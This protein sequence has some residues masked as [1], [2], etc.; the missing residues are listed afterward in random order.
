[1][2]KTQKRIVLIGS[3]GVGKTTLLNKIKN[4]LDL[5]IIE[6]QARIIC[7]EQ[8]FK[9]IYEIK[10]SNLFRQAVLKKQITLEERLKQFIADRSTIDCWVH[11]VRWSYESAKTYES[12]KYYNQAFK[13]ALKY[14]HIIYIPIMF[15]IKKDD[16]RWA[17]PEYQ[18]QI[19]RLVISTLHD[20]SLMKRTHIIQSE[21]INERV[22]EVLNHLNNS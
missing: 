2:K 8:G 13:Q 6:E 16:F 5:Q 14:S 12:E 9:N 20:W 1:M 18:R 7:T 22:K 15:K 17:N 10:D 3:S 11:W 19:D 4:K 21:N